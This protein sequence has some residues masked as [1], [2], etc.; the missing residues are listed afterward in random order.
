M[1]RLFR[2]IC[3]LFKI[4]FRLAIDINDALFIILRNGTVGCNK[5]YRISLHSCR[6]SCSAAANADIPAGIFDGH[7]SIKIANLAIYLHIG[8]GSIFYLPFTYGLFVFFFFRIRQ[9]GVGINL[10]LNLIFQLY[11]AR[12]SIGSAE[13]SCV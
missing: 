11:G 8:N 10:F 5:A 3:L 1:K 9:L 6:T 12:F 13:S 4:P 2:F 7:I